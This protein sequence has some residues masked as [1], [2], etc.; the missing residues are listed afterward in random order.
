MRLV[1]GV[2]DGVQ[3]ADGG[4]VWTRWHARMGEDD[5]LARGAVVAY[6]AQLSAARLW[7]P[8]DAVLLTSAGLGS[9]DLGD[10]RPCERDTPELTTVEL[11]EQTPDGRVSR[12][13]PNRPR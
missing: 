3:V 5:G 8:Q 9:R 6:I 13:G 2:A 1:V 10:C 4:R 12:T 7:S 11:F